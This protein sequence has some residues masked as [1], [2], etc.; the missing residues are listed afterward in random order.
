MK[1]IALLISAAILLMVGV[2]CEKLNVDDNGEN[3]NRRLELSTKSAELVKQGNNFAFELIDRVNQSEKDDFIISP[4]S[5]QFL[6]GMLLDGAQGKTSDEICQVLGY[7]AGEVEAVNE[8]C[9]SMMTQ[10]PK[11]DKKT[12]LSLA[13]A[14]F[15]NKPYTLLDTYKS[16]VGKYYQA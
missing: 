11:L 3:P 10:L 6:L 12:K 4:L 14:I 7:G 15:V 5:M 1:H 9:Q 2:S 8:Y 16:T 13:N